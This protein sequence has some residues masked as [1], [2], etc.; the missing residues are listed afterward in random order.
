MP[1]WLEQPVAVTL[2]YYLADER[3]MRKVSNAFGIAKSTVLKG[4]RRVTMA[5][6]RL[7]GPHYIKHP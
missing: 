7:L 1:L 4:V 3:C 2:S 5:I 6:S